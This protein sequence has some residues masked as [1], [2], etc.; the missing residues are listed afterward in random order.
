MAISFQFLRLS[1]R[2]QR[3]FWLMHCFN[4]SAPLANIFDCMKGHNRKLNRLRA[5]EHNGGGAVKMQDRFFTQ[6]NRSGGIRERWRGLVLT[7]SPLQCYCSTAP[8]PFTQHS[9]VH[10]RCRNW[11]VTAPSNSYAPSITGFNQ[12]GKEKLEKEMERDRQWKG[13][14]PGGGTCFITH[15]ITS[16]IATQAI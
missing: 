2:L 7:Q 1:F 4:E 13:Q 3:V 14:T 5:R 8:T 9:T 6:T 10:N 15:I 16:L 12:R 11:W